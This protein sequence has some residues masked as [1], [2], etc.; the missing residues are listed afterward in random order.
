VWVEA[1]LI[2]IAW[3]SIR[4]GNELMSLISRTSIPD[5]PAEQKAF[6]QAHKHLCKL[7]WIG[8]D[9]DSEYAFTVLR[10][11]GLASR[12]RVKQRLR[13]LSAV[14]EQHLIA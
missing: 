10:A 12:P 3:R 8:R 13:S 1:N 7:R 6:D 5:V 9:V 14:R 2:L 11:A 4:E